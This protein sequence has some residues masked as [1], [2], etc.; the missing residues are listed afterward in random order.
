M[1]IPPNDKQPR[2]LGLILARGGSKR[3]PQK[4]LLPLAGKPLLAW[5]VEAAVTTKHL[6]KIVISTDSEEIAAIGRQYG[7]ESPFLRPVELAGDTTASVDA[8]LH[9]LRT[10]AEN[11]EQ[12]DYVVILQPTSPLRNADDIDA[13]I[14]LLLEKNADAVISVCET[15]HPP[16]W[17]N[18]LPA[19]MSMTHFF[20][21][22]IRE[23]RSQ[24]LPKSYRLNGAVYV[25]NCRRLLDSGSLIMD[26]NCYACLMPR[27]RSVDID[28]EI[29]FEIAG[30]FLKRFGQ[31]V[32]S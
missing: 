11:G 31:G 5:T 10:L 3:L 18:T 17:S 26:D 15:D 1:M 29:D 14:D 12:F 8:I 32:K 28:T 19:D 16:E 4:N 27:E 24:D 9:A 22:G 20:R 7:A 6:D 13:A 2:F 23:T 21:P 30:L 25:Y